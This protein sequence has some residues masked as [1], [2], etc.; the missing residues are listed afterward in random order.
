MTGYIA[1]RQDPCGEFLAQ[2][3]VIVLDYFLLLPGKSGLLSDMLK[4]KKTL[5]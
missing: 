3:A 4:K 1:G 5:I 2:T